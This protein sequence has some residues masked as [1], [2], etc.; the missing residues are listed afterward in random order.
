MIALTP[1]PGYFT[2]PSMAVNPNNPQQVVVAFQD[3]AHVSY[4]NDAGRN[5]D[6]AVGTRN[7]PSLG[8]FCFSQSEWGKDFPWAGSL[9]T[10]TAGP[11][12]ISVSATHG[13]L[14]HGRRRLAGQL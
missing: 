9:G 6:V 4:S 10:R 11:G 14:G 8:S 3:N 12:S 7:G 1:T 2:E 13:S 5:W